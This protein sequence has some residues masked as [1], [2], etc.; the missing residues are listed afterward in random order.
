MISK[1]KTLAKDLLEDNSGGNIN[2]NKNIFLTFIYRGLNILISLI[3]VPI[4]IKFINKT[5]Y[6]IWLTLSS[7]ISWCYFFDVGLGNGLKNKLAESN[8]VKD[9]KS[10]KIYISTTYFII[11][12]I[13]LII[14][15]IALVFNQFINWNSVL[16]V[17]LAINSNLSTVA[18]SVSI[19][20][21]LQFV[22]QLINIILT[23][24][25]EPAKVSLMTLLSQIIILITIA[26]MLNVGHGSL[27]TLVLIIGGIPLAVTI[28]SNFWYFG[29]KY[30]YLRPSIAAINIS[31][32]RSLLLVGGAFFFIQIGQLILYQTDNILV[33]QLFGPADVTV[34]NMSYKLFSI[35][36]TIFTIVITPFWSAFTD[37]YSKKNFSWIKKTFSKVSRI[38]CYTVIFTIILTI[39]SPLIF[40]FW[41]GGLVSIPFSLSISMAAYIIFGTLHMFC[42]YFLN[43]IGKI[44]LQLYMY[45]ICLV[46]NIP[47]SIILSKYIGIT[48]IAYS[49]AIVLIM[50]SIVLYIQC[51]KILNNKA[52]GIWSR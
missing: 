41:I 39:I 49:N 11:S 37:A 43:G 33:S 52:T 26:I 7:I 51:L 34:F 35:V 40:K 20:F 3:L 5:E 12:I 4:T 8:A 38:W 22:F 16:N 32:G 1:F 48:G 9:Y 6:G 23:A 28:L 13:S 30:S 29:N 31:Y 15:I 42:C 19:I 18:L 46:S 2:I 14:I 17:S 36:T 21:C 24:C 45:L 10:S 44:R 47:L 25:H 27:L 50:M